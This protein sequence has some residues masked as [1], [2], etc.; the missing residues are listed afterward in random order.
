MTTKIFKAIKKLHA[1]LRWC[2][3]GTPIQ[4]SLEDLAA[5]VNFIRSYPLDN[6]YTFRK[7]II[8]PLMKRSETGLE[9]LRQI[10]DSVCL[11]RTKQ[12]L[13]LPEIISES[14]LLTFSAR[15]EEKYIETRDTL[16]K[17]INQHSLQPQNKRYPGIFQL[18]LQLRRLCN[19]GTFEKRS[20]GVAEFDP[21]EAITYLMRQKQA[22]CEV[23]SINIT[24]I[25]G[26]EEHRNGSFTTCG[27]LFCSKCAPQMK[28]ALQRVDGT[29]GCLKCSLCLE[30]IFGKYLV[31]KDASSVPS[32]NGGTHLTARQY[33]N[34]GGCSTKVSAL[35]A[36]IEQHKT[37]GKR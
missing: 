15:E 4:N 11:R 32:T 17:M 14:R 13:T 35:V 7:H 21:D 29:D 16:I 2:L 30:T 33:F 28:Q 10:L 18:Q 24:G 6:L 5:L 3:T 31:S 23:C 8:S 19:H 9:N 26:I 27:H 1:T 22:I 25:H 12:L 20:L 36:D 37:E 34:T